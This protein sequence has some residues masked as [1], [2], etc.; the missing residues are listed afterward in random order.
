MLMRG[1]LCT[2]YLLGALGDS[3]RRRRTRVFDVHGGHRATNVCCPNAR[4]RKTSSLALCTTSI[5]QDD[6][7]SVYRL[8][9][10]DIEASR[11]G[12][13]SSHFVAASRGLQAL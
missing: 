12:G 13:A 1:I 6:E 11:G 9:M 10:H 5:A 4:G 7:L 3:C 2:V 8:Q